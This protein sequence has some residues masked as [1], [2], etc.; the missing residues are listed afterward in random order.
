[1]ELNTIPIEV[2]VQNAYSRG[3]IPLN[4]QGI[5]NVKAKKISVTKRSVNLIREYRNYL[6]KTDK[7][8]KFLQVPEP[9]N[10]H[11]LDAVRYAFES[12]TP[13]PIYNAVHKPRDM[14]ALKHRR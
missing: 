4:V 12:M 10:D 8:G 3:A 1:M 13:K 6:W 5:A 2:S 11:A 14:I 7:D 9:G